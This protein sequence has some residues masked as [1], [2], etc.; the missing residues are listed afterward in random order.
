MPKDYDITQIVDRLIG[1]V[2]WHGETSA[3]DK[4]CENLEELELLIFH[5]HRKLV[6]LT[7]TLDSHP[8]NY[9][10]QKLGGKA[11]DI[12]SYLTTNESRRGVSDMSQSNDVRN[13]IIERMRFS[14][15]LESKSFAHPKRTE[16]DWKMENTTITIKL[17]DLADELTDL[18]EQSNREAVR[19]II[20]TIL[21]GRSL[22]EDDDFGWWC[23]TCEMIIEEK[24]RECGCIKI[25]NR[26]QE[27]QH[28][29]GRE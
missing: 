12:L 1:D 19:N 2:S 17:G 29:E 10:A 15:K 3:D 28:P 5:L 4:S 14:T 9:S 16:E 23:E 8:G 22:E 24:E 27:L 25:A 20:Q 18:L 26:L 21:D 7:A 11:K 13:S 6:D